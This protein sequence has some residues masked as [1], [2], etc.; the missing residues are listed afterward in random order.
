MRVTFEDGSFL[1]IMQSVQDENR[2]TFV[3]CGFKD[4]DKLTM[5][6]SEL[7]ISQVEQIKEF[8]EDWRKKL[9]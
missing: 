1:E 5:S 8:L 6:S 4:Y 3:L 7:N 9:E 2:L